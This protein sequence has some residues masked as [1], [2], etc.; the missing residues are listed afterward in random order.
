M[1]ASWTSGLTLS[2]GAKFL[3]MQYDEL[4]ELGE[5]DG[6]MFTVARVKYIKTKKA[7]LPRWCKER[8]NAIGS[9]LNL[10]IV[11]NIHI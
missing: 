3:P 11:I 10:E 2:F 9:R 4:A 5:W 1:L 7:K 6:N 8:E